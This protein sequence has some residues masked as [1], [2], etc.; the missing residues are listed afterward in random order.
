MGP[1]PFQIHRR[2]RFRPRSR[3][4]RRGRR[5]GPDALEGQ[6]R[7]GGGRGKFRSGHPVQD[8]KGLDHFQAFQVIGGWWRT[9]E[10]V[11]LPTRLW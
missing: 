3:H 6:Q 10:T 4:T 2:P 11:A 1:L 5:D 8:A 9:A 7:F